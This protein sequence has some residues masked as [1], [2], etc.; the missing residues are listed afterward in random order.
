MKGQPN[1]Y[2]PGTITKAD[3]TQCRQCRRRE[4]EISI[5]APRLC[6]ACKTE[7]ERVRKLNRKLEKE[8]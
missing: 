2:I 6:R 4:P 8:A 3:P 7:N 5:V 1:G